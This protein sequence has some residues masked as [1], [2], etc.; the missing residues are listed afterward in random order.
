MR[1]K[2]VPAMLQISVFAILAMISMLATAAP[3]AADGQSAA[4]ARSVPSAELVGKGRM[5][6][7][8]FRL[9][10]AELYAPEGTYRAS[11]PFALKLTYLRGFKSEE[12][13]DSSLKEMRRQGGASAGQL[14]RW[15]S[16]MRNLFPDVSKGQS[17]TGV[18]TRR[19][20]AEFYLNGSKL[21]TI[22]DAAFSQRFFA[23]WLGRQTRNPQ[24]RAALT[25]S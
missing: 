15:E 21:G 24:L 17:I 9:F 25:G 18:R 20:E 7:L 16:E 22:G 8:G 4:I 23:I 3:A 6:F 19:G 10:D 14:D 12:I 5:T 2:P 1:S 13:V 11:A